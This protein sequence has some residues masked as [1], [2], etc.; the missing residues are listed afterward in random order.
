M[1]LI[2]YTNNVEDCVILTDAEMDE[3]EEA[4]N[5]GAPFVKVPRLQ[6][7]LP[8]PKFH[9]F[10]SIPGLEQEDLFFRPKTNQVISWHRTTHEAFALKSMSNEEGYYSYTRITQGI[11]PPDKIQAFLKDETLV[12]IDKVINI[13]YPDYIK[14]PGQRAN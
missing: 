6:K 1:K 10:G 9:P 5:N 8:P 12:P 4:W 11:C 2:K 13:V 14:I 7:S 3:V